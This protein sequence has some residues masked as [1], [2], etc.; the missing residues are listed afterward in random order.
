MYKLQIPISA[1]IYKQFAL[2]LAVK[3]NQLPIY[4][5]EDHI[6]TEHHYSFEIFVRK[7]QS[8]VDVEN[9]AHYFNISKEM[10]EINTIHTFACKRLQLSYLIRAAVA[11]R[12][13]YLRGKH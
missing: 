9:F 8:M 4:Q 3:Y 11:A 7:F 5:E 13:K 12:Q 6:L 1:N 10:F 2:F